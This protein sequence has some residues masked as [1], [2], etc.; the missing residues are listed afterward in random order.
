MLQQQQQSLERRVLSSSSSTNWSRVTLDSVNKTGRLNVA[1]VTLFLSSLIAS[2]SVFSGK[3]AIYLS[4]FLLGN[5]GHRAAAFRR[6]PVS[7]R[8]VCL[9]EVVPFSSPLAPLTFS[10]VWSQGEVCSIKTIHERECCPGFDVMPGQMG[11]LRVKPADAMISTLISNNASIFARHL[12]ESGLRDQLEQ[13]GAFTVFAPNDQT[14]SSLQTMR[15]ISVSQLQQIS[16]ARKPT[17][18]P[19]LLYHLAPTR[20]KLEDGAVIK[21]SLAD[22]TLRI[23]R[24]RH[25]VLTVNCV[26]L[27]RTYVM[28]KEGVMHLLSKPLDPSPT[29]NLM[30]TILGDERVQTFAT[31]IV[32]AQLAGDFRDDGPFTIFA[33]TQ[34]AFSSLPGNFFES[35]LY[36]TDAIKG[37]RRLC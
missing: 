22:R 13:D 16:S 35:I 27:E 19:F 4:L 18:V 34:D 12:A 9:Y 8:N 2:G 23:N 25:D 37:E 31:L 20:V 24:Q 33:P 5:G 7:G 36:N 21:T 14:T 32:Q 26:P 11:C 28:A 1:Q 3:F 6:S 29:F 17:E 30:D 10:R 15:T